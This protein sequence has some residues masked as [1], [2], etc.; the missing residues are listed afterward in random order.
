M[1]NHPSADVLEQYFLGTLKGPL[2]DEVEEHLLVCEQCQDDLADCDEY[3]GAMKLATA[4]L[5][6]EKPLDVKSRGWRSWFR[7]SGWLSKPI[8]A[9]AL[10]A[11]ALSVMILIPRTSPE[12]RTIEVTLR[13]MRGP[14]AEVSQAPA[15]RPFVLNADAAGLPEAGQYSMEI[16]DGSGAAV[17]HGTPVRTGDRVRAEIPARL[18]AGRY[19]VRLSNSS[20]TLLREY[21]LEVRT[22]AAP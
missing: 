21:A 9:G 20:G 5:R 7:V 14:S 10:A 8:W 16:A 17:W 12:G 19:W 22:T 1:E 18:A 4:N 11:I 2:L 3:V 6:K 13:T 15:E